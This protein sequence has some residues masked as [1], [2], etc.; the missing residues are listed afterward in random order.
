MNEH[1]WTWRCA[2]R[3]HEQWPRVDH[4]DLENVAQ[5]LYREDRWRGLEPDAAAVEWLQQGIPKG[6]SGTSREFTGPR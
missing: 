2:V 6:S 3:L 4:H 1:E 5:A